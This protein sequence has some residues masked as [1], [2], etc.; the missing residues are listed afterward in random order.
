MVILSFIGDNKR[1]YFSLKKVFFFSLTLFSS[2]G[3]F[4]AGSTCDIKLVNNVANCVN[5][6]STFFTTRNL[7]YAGAA[8]ATPGSNLGVIQLRKNF[9]EYL[10]AN[11]EELIKLGANQGHINWSEDWKKDAVGARKADAA[12]ELAKLNAALAEGKKVIGWPGAGKNLYPPLLKEVNGVL[13]DIANVSIELLPEQFHSN[14]I[15]SAQVA[16]DS[17]MEQLKQ[18][19]ALDK[20]WR[21]QTGASIH[22]AWLARNPQA[23]THPVQG[24][25]FQEMLRMAESEPNLVLRAE[26]KANVALDLRRIDSIANIVSQH[27]KSKGLSST[28]S[29]ALGRI[30]NSNLAKTMAAAAGQ[31]LGAGLIA[32]ELDGDTAFDPNSCLKPDAELAEGKKDFVSGQNFRVRDIINISFRRGCY[33]KPPPDY[34]ADSRVLSFLI[35]PDEEKIEALKVPEVCEYYKKLEVNTCS[36]TQV[37]EKESS[38]NS[39]KGNATVS[40]K[41]LTSSEEIKVDVSF[42]PSGNIKSVRG[43]NSNGYIRNP[44]DG[45]WQPYSV[46]L[47]RRNPGTQPPA[48][49]WT[50]YDEATSPITASHKQIF[51]GF[52]TK[53]GWDIAANFKSIQKLVDGCNGTGTSTTPTGTGTDSGTGTDTTGNK[54]N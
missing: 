24:K 9:S 53:A 2:I 46:P 31:V 26:A 34:T 10:L 27:A 5:A 17:A 20:S 35:L 25:S 33:P 23:K 41:N 40:I 44:K 19:K 3:V 4:A 30:A 54:K 51:T 15:K 49:F 18:G 21:L 45:S 38:C 36:Q 39:E 28:I 16:L 14:N 50:M 6:K 11:R 32:M 43:P 13:Y 48:S 37:S 52:E 1:V 8:V 7:A 12:R 22:E 47:A 42:D 29:L